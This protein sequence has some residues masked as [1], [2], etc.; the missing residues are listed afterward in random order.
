MDVDHRLQPMPHRLEV[1]DH[2]ADVGDRLDELGLELVGEGAVDAVDLQLGPGLEQPARGRAVVLGAGG[3]DGADRHQRAV[4]V[5]RHGQHRVHEQV[6]VEPVSFEQH[7]HRVD[8]ERHVVGDGE[9]TRVGGA[10]C[11]S[12]AF[13]RAHPHQRHAATADPPEVVVGRGR[14]VQVVDV[15]LADI[16]LG[17]GVVVHRDEVGE[18][19][20]VRATCHGQLAESRSGLGGIDVALHR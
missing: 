6:D 15:V 10:P 14:G 3:V 13:G 4:V 20:V 12:V 2:A 18:H 19:R 7:P 16:V 5:A 11:V 1:G 17:E 9:H 8:E